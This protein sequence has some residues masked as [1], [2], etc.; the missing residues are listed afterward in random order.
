MDNQ[1]QQHQIE[2]IFNQMNELVARNRRIETSVFKVREHMGLVDPDAECP[3]KVAT[4]SRV[5]IRAWDGSLGAIKRA[6]ENEKLFRHDHPV[7]VFFRGEC[8]AM[9]AFD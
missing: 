1:V 4:S 3:V 9:V 5:D 2:Q 6:L 7:K 8:V